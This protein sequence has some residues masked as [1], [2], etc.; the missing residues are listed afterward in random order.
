MPIEESNALDIRQRTLLALQ[1]GASYLLAPRKAITV[2]LGASILA[3]RF[4]VQTVN[5]AATE[6]E[7]QLGEINGSFTQAVTSFWGRD[8]PAENSH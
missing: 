2:V 1:S 3:R 5:D 8:A 7:R 4:F 6:G